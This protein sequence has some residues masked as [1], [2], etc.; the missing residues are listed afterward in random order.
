M[1]DYES[2]YT[3][4][5]KQAA[6]RDAI[7]RM[8]PVHQHWR[9]L[10][11][12]YRIGAQRE[13]TAIDL[14][15]ILPFPTP[16]TF[17]RTV[18]MVLPHLNLIINS[19]TARDPKLIVTPIGGDETVIEQN[20]TIAKA[21]LDYFWRRTASTDVLRDMT[22][23][24]VVIGNGFCKVGWSYS[25]STSDRTDDDIASEVDELM[26]TAI[27]VAEE[28]GTPLDDDAIAEIVKSVS[29][30]NNLVETDEPFV[31]YVSPYD[32]YVPA[33]ARR[34]NSTRWI[35]QKLR[36][37]IEELKANK[38]F[39]KKA[40][41][42]IVPDTGYAERETIQRYEDQVG[43]L[44][45]IFSHATVY[46]FYDMDARTI[47]VF[48]LDSETPLYEGPIPYAHRYPPFVHMRN[49]NDGGQT[50][51]SFG[52]V[53][54]VAGLQLM[55]NEIMV[56]QINDLKRV[57]N[58]YFVNKKILTPELAKAL[59]EN[60]PDAVIPIDVP[61]N[62]SIGEVLVPVQRLA[63]PSDNYMMEGKMQDYMQR[64]LGIT[65]LQ[66]GAVS[67]ASRVPAT[68]AAA[69]EGASTLRSMDKQVNVE[70]S[71]RE[72]GTRMLGLC[73][74]FLDEGRAVR[75]AGPDAPQWLQVSSDDIEGEFSIETEGGS[76]QAVNPLTK[77]RQGMELLTQVAPLLAQMGYDPENAVRSALTYMGL[78][79]DHL[80][81]RPPQQPAP[82]GP[83]AGM[84]PGMDQGLPPEMGG[85][86]PMGEPPVDMNNPAIAQL[87]G[88]GGPPMPG[89]AEGE[90][91]I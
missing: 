71:S 52:D 78:N 80:L 72:I 20:A 56:A 41:S 91:L 26:Q 16:G 86:P 73:Q 29:L 49:F 53:E 25:E 44:P 3:T 60:K 66:A 28:L 10:E 75:I 4:K 40:V 38:L 39:D 14:N 23:D 31:E 1:A 59:Q 58:K 63:T 7:R 8:E 45:T 24:M 12:L 17:L 50:F 19:V 42:E 5:D 88:L 64:I 36:L 77:A 76:T 79:P 18:N 57:G 82:A 6:L 9:M 65:D 51:W 43:T 2:K 70:R 90:S 34:L 74:Q 15:R 32:M 87:M 47:C 33:N 62:V 37:P 55:V 22:Q 67:V 89:V 68:A 46:E 30:T 81:V 13:V 11:S 69:V 48:Q 27:E 84:A 83:E 21:V 35:A 85:M 54:N 61:G